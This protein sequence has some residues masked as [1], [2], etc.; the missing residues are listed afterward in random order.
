MRSVPHCE[1]RDRGQ[2][3]VAAPG[4][5]D[6]LQASVRLVAARVAEHQHAEVA[7][8]QRGARC[9]QLVVL[10]VV[11]DHITDRR[12]IP[13]PHFAYARSGFRPPERNVARR[14]ASGDVAACC[15]FASAWVSILLSLYC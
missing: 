7:D 13:R 8:A 14:S 6:L 4:L 15:L 11:G 2:R 10:I 9:G 1:Q 3:H 5:H 12:V